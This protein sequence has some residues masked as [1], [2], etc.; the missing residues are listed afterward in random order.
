MTEHDQDT[1]MFYAFR[2]VLGRMTYAV[3]DVVELIIRYKSIISE[4]HKS[5]MIKEINEAIENGHAGMD[6][7]ISEWKNV[8]ETLE[9]YNK[10]VQ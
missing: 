10:G 2:Y 9:C 5:L 7:D 8:L 4:N 3:S 6:C 1:L